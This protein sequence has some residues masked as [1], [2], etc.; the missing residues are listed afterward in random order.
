MDT[1]PVRIVKSVSSLGAA[2][3]WQGR[4]AGWESREIRIDV[5]RPAERY[6]GLE[7]YR[8]YR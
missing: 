8:G 7:V 4:F 2:P 1:N 5:Y 3:E 6:V